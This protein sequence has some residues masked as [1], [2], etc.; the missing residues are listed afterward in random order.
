MVSTSS[1]TLFNNFLYQAAMKDFCKCKLVPLPCQKRWFPVCLRVALSS[2]GACEGLPA[3]RA[4]PSCAGVPQTPRCLQS[5]PP[6]AASHPCFPKAALCLACSLPRPQDLKGFFSFS[7]PYS[8]LTLCLKP[9]LK[10]PN[11]DNHP[12]LRFSLCHRRPAAAACGTLD[13]I[14]CLQWSCVSYRVW[15]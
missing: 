2:S 3:L 5:W 10:T 8:V 14:A 12:S 15:F 11:R 13:V 1:F 6:H 7:K 9:L 4:G